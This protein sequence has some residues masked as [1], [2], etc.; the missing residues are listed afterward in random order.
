LATACAFEHKKEQGKAASAISS[1]DRAVGYQE[2]FDTVLSPRCISCHSAGGGN[3]GGVNLETYESTF[4]LAS[5]IER[6]TLTDKTMPKGQS[7]S[8]SEISILG[9]WLAQGATRNGS[10]G[11]SNSKL[12][13]RVNWAVVREEVLGKKCLDCHS[14]PRPEKNLDLTSL[15]ATRANASKIFERAVITQDMPLPP[16]DRLTTEEKQALAQWIAAG[17]PE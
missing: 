16:F 3:Q 10:M 14:L 7:L 11:S 5:R 15:D 12:R 17:M 13:G 8:D 2:V 4:P 6:T 1:L 9:A